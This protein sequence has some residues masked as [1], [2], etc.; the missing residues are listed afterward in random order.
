MD[1]DD[2][3]V[4]F[5]LTAYRDRAAARRFLEQA[6]DLHDLPQKI[7]IDKSGANTAAIASVIAD[8]GVP[9]QLR[10]SKYLNNLVEQE[11][12]FIKRMIRPKLGFKSFRGASIVLAGIETKHLIRKGQLRRTQGQA[13]SAANQFYSLAF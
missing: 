4:D 12:R 5:L 8:T 3:T 1:C 6:I 2:D 9:I 11:H 13:T 7:T 10:Q